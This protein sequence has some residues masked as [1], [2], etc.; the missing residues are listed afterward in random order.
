MVIVCQWMVQALLQM[1]DLEK[2][3][4]AIASRSK[5]LENLADMNGI[6]WI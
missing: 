1:F 3:A 2:L 4:T 5:Y 6:V